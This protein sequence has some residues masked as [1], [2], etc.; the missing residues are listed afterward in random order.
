M[1]QVSIPCVAHFPLE[2]RP[3]KVD[4]SQLTNA[5]HLLP[6]NYS[7][8]EHHGSIYCPG[9][10]V[11]CSRIPRKKARRTDNVHAFYAHIRGF[12][13][14]S[15]PHRKTG[16]RASVDGIAK[17]KKAINLVTFA[18]WKRLEDDEAESEEDGQV[19][20]SKRLVQGRTAG[21]GRGVKLVFDA[22]ESVLNAGKF[23]TVRRLVMHAK[24]DLDTYVQFTDQEATRL[25]DLIVWIEKVQ[26]DSL[27]YI[28]KSF[29][30]FGQPTSIVKGTHQVFFN[31]KEHGHDLAGYCDPR[32]FERRGW[33]TSECGR[34]Y[35]FYG[36]LEGHES[37]SHVR[38]LDS[39]QIDRFS[40]S[41]ALLNS[42]C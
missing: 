22:S 31:F 35:I 23:R 40:L 34:Y 3:S 14:I 37:C 13:D 1:S 28:G 11:M 38:I 39:G 21:N 41:H 9:C 26:K 18:D 15:C 36:L 30:F 27:R 12:D 32:V 19:S 5:V 4:P 24:R 8:D 10:G 7:D 33:K 42:L 25:G 2:G 20:K 17:K 6:E 29:L 16:G